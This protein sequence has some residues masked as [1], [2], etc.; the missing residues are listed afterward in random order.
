VKKYRIPDLGS[1]SATL[2]LS[3]DNPF[4][5]ENNLNYSGFVNMIQTGMLALQLLP[6]NSSAGI[7]VI[8]DGVIRLVIST[9][10]ILTRMHIAQ[11]IPV[12]SHH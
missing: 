8:T 6:D 4:L 9:G 10:I 7:I 1:G 12:H 11:P 5:I 2:L 3:C